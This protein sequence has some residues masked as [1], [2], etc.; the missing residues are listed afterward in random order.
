M[1][2][3]KEISLSDLRPGDLFTA[4]IVT[5][6]P[7]K[8]VSERE[9]KAM[10]TGAP[11]APAPAP[12]AAAPAPAPAPARAPAPAAEAAPAHAKMPKTAS[13]VPLAGLMGGLSIAVA[14][15][16]S[17]IRRSRKR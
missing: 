15:G 2:D 14:L 9:A 8:V 1:K 11:P 4:V 17:R 3:G 6:H 16:L 12:V 5:D 13:Q 7:P 10:V